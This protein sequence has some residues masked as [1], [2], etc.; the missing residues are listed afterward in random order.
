PTASLDCSP[1]G[2]TAEAP[3]ATQLANRQHKG[4]GG[5]PS[6][7]VPGPATTESGH[8]RSSGRDE[9][10]IG[11]FTLALRPLFDQ[12]RVDYQLPGPFG[13]AIF[14]TFLLALFLIVR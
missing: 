3:V 7:L 8:W 5:V 1:C 6:G 9:P 4:A 13:T 14:V 12:L 11:R 10:L 2:S